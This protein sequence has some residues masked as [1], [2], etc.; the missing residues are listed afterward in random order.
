MSGYLNEFLFRMNLISVPI[1][2]TGSEALAM[3]V[4]AQS[5]SWEVMPMVVML[6]L[7]GLELIPKVLYEAGSIDGTS[8]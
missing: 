5:D 1:D 2:G 6:F 3:L 7:S 4:V 8:A